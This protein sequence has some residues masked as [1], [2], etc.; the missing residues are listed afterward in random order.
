MGLRERKARACRLLGCAAATFALAALALPQ[1]A[2]AAAYQSVDTPVYAATSEG[3]TVTAEVGEV[4]KETWSYPVSVEVTIAPGVTAE[5]LDANLSAA[6][7]EVKWVT[8]KNGWLQPGDSV[9]VAVR[10][11][12]ESAVTYRYRSGSLKLGTTGATPHAGA[13]EVAAFDGRPVYIGS[14]ERF[15]NCVYRSFNEPLRV[16][17]DL[18]EPDRWTPPSQVDEY[19]EWIERIFTDEGGYLTSTLK[20]AGHDSLAA[21]YIAYY[22]EHLDEYGGAQPIEHLQDASVAYLDELFCCLGARGANGQGGAWVRE[23]E[24][25]LAA[26]GYYYLYGRLLTVNGTP[27]GQLMAKGAKYDDLD[28]AYAKQGLLAPGA[29]VELPALTYVLDGPNT[30]NCYQN[31]AINLGACFSVER[32]Y[33]ASVY[34]YDATDEAHA[35]KGAE[36]AL[37]ADEA[38]TQRVGDA[39]IVTGAD[40]TAQLLS[41]VT[42]GTYWLK[43]VTAPEGYD[44]LSEPVRVELNAKALGDRD[45][46]VVRVANTLTPAPEPEPEPKP[47]PKPEPT[48][49]PEPEPEPKPESTPD[50]EPKP[51]PKPETLPHTGDVQLIAAAGTSVIGTCVIFSGMRSRRR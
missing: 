33:D 48:P 38:C 11:K 22:N 16:L 29:T 25:E 34:K 4:D 39:A 23:T 1:Q 13:S 7:G 42:A 35:L 8:E 37:Y 28:A 41:G 43:E 5:E 27:V 20:K 17:F 30:R 2:L 45:A 10:V 32:V 36:F 50:P 47:E 24:P 40:G 44:A 51:E 14:S 26:L 21:Y 18:P 3:V 19:N 9:A 15:Q 46:L 49:D 12:N 6:I 31:H